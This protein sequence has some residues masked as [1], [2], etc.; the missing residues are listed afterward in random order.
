MKLRLLILALFLVACGGGA[1]T[2]IG[3]IGRHHD[4]ELSVT[5]WTYG[6]A[7]SCIPDWQL[8]PPAGK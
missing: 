6:T 8:K 1:E 2:G 5:C 4:D 7:I 3:P